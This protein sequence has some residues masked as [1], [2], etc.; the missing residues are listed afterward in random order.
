MLDDH[1]FFRIVIKYYLF[2][3]CVEKVYVPYGYM[4]KLHGLWFFSYEEI[5]SHISYYIHY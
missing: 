2:T 1:L 5:Y 4:S 3:W